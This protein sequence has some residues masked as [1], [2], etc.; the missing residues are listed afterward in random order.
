VAADALC[1]APT[2]A[3]GLP[4]FLRL[5]TAYA[6][7]VPASAVP[8]VPE[9]LLRLADERGSTQ[10]HLEARRL[11]EALEAAQTAAP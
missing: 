11:V 8:A 2:K 7:E 1:A 5:L 10:R 6:H 9:G 3:S 4:D